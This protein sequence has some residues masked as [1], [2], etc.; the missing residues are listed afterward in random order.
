MIARHPDRAT[1]TL[2]E[3]LQRE[4]DRRKWSVVDLEAQTGVSRGALRN[5]LKNK[6][7]VPTIGTLRRLAIRFEMPLLRMVEL[8]GFDLG[9]PDSLPKG[10]TARII[11]LDQ[12]MPELHE[13]LEHLVDRS[14]DEMAGVLAYLEALK[15][16][17]DAAG[18]GPGEPAK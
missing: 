9:T 13:A 8:A 5:I 4:M 12:A 7:A 16:R 3:F 11:A 15:R 10:R 17:R 18:L 6:D 2:A 1:V 14:P